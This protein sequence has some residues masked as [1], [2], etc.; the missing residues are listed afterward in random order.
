MPLIG[1]FNVNSMRYSIKQEI[2]QRLRN[3]KKLEGGKKTNYFSALYL[4][5]GK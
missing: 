1:A 2:N 3:K 4:S 5:D